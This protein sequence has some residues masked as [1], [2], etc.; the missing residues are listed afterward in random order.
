MT[1]LFKSNISYM[2]KKIQDLARDFIDNSDYFSQETIADLDIKHKDI[3][4]SHYQ[5][6]NLS[7]NFNEK[8]FRNWNKQ[9]DL[10]VPIQL[11]LR[12]LLSKKIFFNLA[13][14]I[15]EN[16]IDLYQTKFRKQGLIDDLQIIKSIGAEGI[17]KENPVD[18]TPGGTIAYL[19]E[20]FSFNSRWLRY[21]Y[22]TK[23][24]LSLFETNSNFTWLDIGCYY[25]GLQ[26]LVKKYRPNTKIFLV[27]FNHQLCRSYIY[28][29]LLYSNAKHILPN[30]ISS[31][32]NLD[33]VHDGS[34]V[35]IPIEKYSL[36][37]DKK[38]NLSTNFFSFGEMNTETFLN[39]FNSI[40]FQKSDLVF[41]VNRFVSGPFFNPTYPNKT[42][43][44]HYINEDREIKYFDIFP[45]HFSHI[46]EGKLFETLGLRPI[47]SQYFEILTKLR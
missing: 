31:N 32:F 21:V 14:Y 43:F 4:S 6:F 36:I 22:L 23:R 1:I 45:I 9:S 25:G 42:N 8:N 5:N 17:L 15:Y 28:L 41:L 7:A 12:N 30:Q 47:S 3:V 34:I 33:L 10:P 39:Y 38:F 19:K 13:R 29:K 46:N 2:D 27:D 26:G 16:T 37:K 18:K 24:I 20:G 40:P 11:S 44:F 35:Y